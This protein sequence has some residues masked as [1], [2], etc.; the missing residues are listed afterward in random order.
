MASQQVTLMINN[1]LIKSRQKHVDNARAGQY[2][3]RIASVGGADGGPYSM[4]FTNAPNEIVYGQY[5]LIGTSTNGVQHTREQLA[6][7]VTELHRLR[8]RG[9]TRYRWVTGLI[10]ILTTPDD[11]DIPTIFILRNNGIITGYVAI[12]GDGYGDDLRMECLNNDRNVLSTMVD[13]YFDSMQR[14]ENI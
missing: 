3:H 5:R 12:F 14:W 2:V 4:N 9:V 8:N 13:F 6:P 1:T 11:H 7:L 10:R